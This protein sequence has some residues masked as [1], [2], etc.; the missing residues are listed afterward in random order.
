MLKSQYKTMTKS[1]QPSFYMAGAAN[2]PGNS[3]RLVG[4]EFVQFR[5]V[6]KSKPPFKLSAVW[7]YELGNMGW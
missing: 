7:G 6:L 4:L 3:L 1:S 2:R 5:P